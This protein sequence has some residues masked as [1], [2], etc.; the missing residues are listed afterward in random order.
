MFKRKIRSAANLGVH[1]NAVWLLLGVEI[2]QFFCWSWS[3]LMFFTLVITGYLFTLSSDLES[4]T[5]KVT[6]FQ[7]NEEIN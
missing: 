5:P 4:W 3:V 1:Q 7:L 2:T 6:Q